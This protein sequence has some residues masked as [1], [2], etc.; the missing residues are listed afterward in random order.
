M[1]SYLLCEFTRPQVLGL[2]SAL[3][4]YS[5]AAVKRLNEI[6]ERHLCCDTY[7]RSFCI[8]NT[9]NAIKQRD[10]GLS[11]SRC[12]RFGKRT[13]LENRPEDS[14]PGDAIRWERAAASRAS[15]SHNRGVR[16]HGAFRSRAPSALSIAAVIT[17][18]D[19]PAANRC[20]AV[21]LAKIAKLQSRRPCARHATPGDSCLLVFAMS[22]PCVHAARK[23]ENRLVVGS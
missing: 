6:N 10:R 23:R 17:S 19:A 2:T 21:T 13:E 7:L 5:S 8:I 4:S 18:A 9:T 11:S 3:T 14:A 15:R 12:P 22:R 20:A 16:F 1:S